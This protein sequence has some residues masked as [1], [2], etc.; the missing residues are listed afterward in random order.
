MIG[1]G[2]SCSD[3]WNVGLFTETVKHNT[4]NILLQ[5]YKNYVNKLPVN[6]KHLEQ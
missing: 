2:A 6:I 3:D 4:E 5:V 1:S